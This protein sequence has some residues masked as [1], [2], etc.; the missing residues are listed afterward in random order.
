MENKERLL[1]ELHVELAIKEQNEENQSV[2][3]DNLERIDRLVES[4][5]KLTKEIKYA[6]NN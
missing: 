6:K 2:D 3:D 5:N 1:N 4:I